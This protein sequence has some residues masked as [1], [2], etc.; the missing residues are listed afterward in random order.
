MRSGGTWV[1][2]VDAVPIVG[3]HQ[4]PDTTRTTNYDITG[5]DKEERTSYADVVRGKIVNE[6]E[7]EGNGLILLE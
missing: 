3:E 2:T 1:D 4:K 7:H 5:T 6:Q